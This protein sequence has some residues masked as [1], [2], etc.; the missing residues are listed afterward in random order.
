MKRFRFH[1]GTLLLIIL[2]VGIGLA[3][4]RES[5]DLWE[6]GIFATT[7]GILLISILLAVHRRE[8]RR[9]FWIGFTLIGWIYLGLTFMPSIESRL[10]T[11]KA[12]AFVKPAVHG[13][14][15]IGLATFDYD[16]GSIDLYVVNDSQ[17]PVLYHNNGNGT[18]AD[19][20]AVAGLKPAGK[21]AWFPNI[22]A[23]PALTGLGTTENFV[24]IGHSLLAL[25]AASV[26]GLL[27]RR[28]H[29]RNHGRASGP[30]A[31]R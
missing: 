28:L 26:G 29:F 2:F 6:S 9:A 22:L 11:T 1:I 18:F 20:T 8:A 12:L 7:L 27:S 5:S 30:L 23:G 19:V 21:Q 17:S 13:R 24:R 16:D 31:S 25:I 14:A 3:A 10:V 4:L 15:P